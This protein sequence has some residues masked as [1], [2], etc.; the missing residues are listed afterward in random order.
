MPE[1]LKVLNDVSYKKKLLI[2]SYYVSSI[3]T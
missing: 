3:A 1:K 2:V